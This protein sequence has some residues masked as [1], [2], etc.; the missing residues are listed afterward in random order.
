M[1]DPGWLAEQIAA[2]LAVVEIAQGAGVTDKTVRT[3]IARHGLPRPHRRPDPRLGNLDAAVAAVRAG[4]TM[5]EALAAGMV[6]RDRLRRR[7]A[8]LGIRKTAR[9]L[10]PSKFPRL[11][12][13]RWLSAML[14]EGVPLAAIARAVG[15]ERQAVRYAV[16]R[17]GLTMPGS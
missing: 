1:A 17:H 12:D 13:P 14:A 9:E 4:S 2:G 5:K 15:C 11:N 3:A 16:R 10:T 8:E 6:S 7:L